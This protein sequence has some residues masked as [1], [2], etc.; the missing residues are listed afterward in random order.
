M[1]AQLSHIPSDLPYHP[2]T[3]DLAARENIVSDLST[4]SPSITSNAANGST[5][6]PEPRTTLPQIESS[7][8]P[9][10]FLY[11]HIVTVSSSTSH[12]ATKNL[13]D[14]FTASYSESLP[15]RSDTENI[16]TLTDT[17]RNRAHQRGP[18]NMASQRPNQ[19]EDEQRGSTEE[20]VG[21][22]GTS[23][24]PSCAYNLAPM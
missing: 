19:V 23:Y 16:H 3:I 8:Q 6:A 11:C 9:S 4:P 22:G 20:A 5:A 14:T 10:A 12:I 1:L 18:R 7:S 21:L 15:S 24:S 2:Q 13:E 17:A